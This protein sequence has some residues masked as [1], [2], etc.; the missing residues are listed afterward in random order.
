MESSHSE[1]SQD[2]QMDGCEGGK[3]GLEGQKHGGM[4]GLGRNSRSRGLAK[5]RE[6]KERWKAAC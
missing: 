3:R 6:E 5:V 1:A 2:R 4:E